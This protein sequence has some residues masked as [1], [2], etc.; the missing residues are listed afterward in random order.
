MYFFVDSFSVYYL[1]PMLFNSNFSFK[2]CVRISMIPYIMNE[3]IKKLSFLTFRLS[4][5]NVQKVLCVW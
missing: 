4:S 1:L 5:K 2:K 3:I